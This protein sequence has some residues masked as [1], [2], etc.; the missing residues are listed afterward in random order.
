MSALRIIPGKR[1]PRTSSRESAM[2]KPH[3]LALAVAACLLSSAAFADPA[4]STAASVAAT[5]SA[6]ANPPIGSR[7]SAVQSPAWLVH[8]GTATPL[9]PGMT[10]ADGDTLRTAAGGRVYLQLP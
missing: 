1:P 10:V 5:A 8:G 4:A 3:S 9:K 7:V 6:P 2:S